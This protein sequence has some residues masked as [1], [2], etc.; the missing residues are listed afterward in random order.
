LPSDLPFE[1][2][3]DALMD[4]ESGCLWAAY[5]FRSELDAHPLLAHWLGLEVISL[6]LT[7]PRFYHL[8]TCF[9]P[10]EGGFLLI[11]TRF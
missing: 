9:C 2:A 8:D 3:G 4:R 11:P 6:R 5:G 7:D 1:G 10:L